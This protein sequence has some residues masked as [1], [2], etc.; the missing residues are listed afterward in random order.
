MRSLFIIVI[1]VNEFGISIDHDKLYI[2]IYIYIYIQ[3]C[4]LDLSITTD[5][6][7]QDVFFSFKT[8]VNSQTLS[9]GLK[10]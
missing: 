8:D 7:R 10:R 1:T 9:N 2:Y 3:T 4:I 6:L 5:A